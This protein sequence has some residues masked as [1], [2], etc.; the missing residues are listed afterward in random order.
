MKSVFRDPSVDFWHRGCASSTPQSGG[1]PAVPSPCSARARHSTIPRRA[2]PHPQCL[3]PSCSCKL[4]ALPYPNADAPHTERLPSTGATGYIGGDVLAAVAAAHPDWHVT[5]LVRSETRGAAVA[6]AHPSVRLVYGDLA[7]DDLIKGEAAAADIVLRACSPCLPS[8]RT[9]AS[10][11]SA[12][13]QQRRAGDA[14]NGTP[15][16]T[17]PTPMMKPRR[18]PSQPVSLNTARTGRASGSTPLARASCATPTS[19]CRP[20]ATTPQESGTTSPTCPPSATTSPLTPRTAPSTRSSSQRRE[21]ALASRRRLCARRAS[22]AT[23]EAPSTSAAYRS[24][25]WR[26]RASSGSADSSWVRAAIA[27]PTCM[28]ATWRTCM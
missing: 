9:N 21:D 6:A 15:P 27:G 17:A 20:T 25:R 12:P 10:Y 16:Q 18:A 3:H 2:T 13:A 28:S 24:P 14:A 19:T 4:P 22:T 5:C 23:A 8:S 1:N 7:S 11:P 26:A